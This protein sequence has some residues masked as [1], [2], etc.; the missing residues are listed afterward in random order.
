MSVQMKGYVRRRGSPG[1]WKWDWIMYG[2]MEE[3]HR[4]YYRPLL[5]SHASAERSLRRAAA[6]FGVTLTEIIHDDSGD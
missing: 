5:K 3:I 1:R 6:R 2:A 4:N